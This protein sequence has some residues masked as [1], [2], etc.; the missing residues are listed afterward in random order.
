MD[1][2]T[3]AVDGCGKPSR[4]KSLCSAHHSRLLR[5][6]DVQAHIPLRGQ[7]DTSSSMWCSSCE[8]IKATKDFYRNKATKRGYDGICKDCLN[9][10]LE[11][12]Q[13]TIRLNAKMSRERNR[14]KRLA[15]KRADYRRNRER[16]IEAGR[17]WRKENPEKSRMLIRAQNSARYARIKS[18]SGR[19]SSLDMQARWDYYGGKCWM[20]G[21][22]ATDSDHVKPLAKGGSNWPANIRPACRSCNRSKSAAWPYPLEV[23]RG[24]S[25][26]AGKGTAK[27]A[28]PL[29]VH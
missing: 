13:V 6:G 16:S 12:N 10:R 8:A 24:R 29:A 18:A 27:P 21:A 15:R 26:S 22:T 1:N 11:R 9:A 19:S 2:V 25:A 20:C 28:V 7:S 5:K 17:R 14:D 3:C 4:T 23:A